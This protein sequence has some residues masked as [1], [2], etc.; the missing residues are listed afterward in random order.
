MVFHKIKKKK[1]H[2]ICQNTANVQS[3]VFCGM[4]N[5]LLLLFI[6]LCKNALAGFTVMLTLAYA[7]G[8][9]WYSNRPLMIVF[10]RE[11]LDTINKIAGMFGPTQTELTIEEDG[12]ALHGVLMSMA[13][14]FLSGWP[15][16]ILSIFFPLSFEVVFVV[17]LGSIIIPCRDRA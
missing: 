4:S 8:L 9:M 13:A 11:W 15:M 10:I 1:Q 5:L 12:E 16:L 17:G 2:F 3:L 7:F 6:Q 14:G